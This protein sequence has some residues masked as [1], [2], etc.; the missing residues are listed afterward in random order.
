S[1]ATATVKTEQGL[2]ITVGYKLFDEVRF[3]LTRGQPTKNASIP[4]LELHIALLRDLITRA[5]HPFVEIPAVPAGYNFI[6]CLSHDIDHPVLRNHR[7]DH[8]M[9]GYLLRAV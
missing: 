6:G 2:G 8:T 3:L 9:S 1:P 7:F 5:G 4:T